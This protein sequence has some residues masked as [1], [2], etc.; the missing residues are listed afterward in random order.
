L[1]SFHGPDEFFGSLDH[2]NAEEEPEM[3]DSPDPDGFP[4]FHERF[5]LRGVFHSWARR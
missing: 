3:Y 5:G 4:R 2:L 1:P